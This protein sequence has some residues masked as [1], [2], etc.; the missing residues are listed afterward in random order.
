MYNDVYF[1]EMEFCK[2]T[3]WLEQ[4]L[5]EQIYLFDNVTIHLVRDTGKG[6]FQESWNGNWPVPQWG[7]A[8]ALRTSLMPS[9]A[10]LLGKVIPTYSQNYLHLP[11]LTKPRGK[12]LSVGEECENSRTDGWSRKPRE[13]QRENKGVSCDESLPSG[14]KFQ[15]PL[16][17]QH[18]SKACILCWKKKKCGKWS[19]EPHLRAH[20]PHTG[21]KSGREPGQAGTCDI[22]TSPARVSK[23]GDCGWAEDAQFKSPFSLNAANFMLFC[24]SRITAWIFRKR[25]SSFFFS[26]C[27]VIKVNENQ[28]F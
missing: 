7:E 13:G 6:I 26:Y 24:P 16:H 10:L 22:C 18:L 25:F 1:P 15:K 27:L 20:R 14:K 28:S 21:Q 23:Q 19:I 8:K 12:L 3:P 9:W 5:G 2:S 4:G 11:H 17:P